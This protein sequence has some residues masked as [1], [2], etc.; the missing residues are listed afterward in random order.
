MGRRKGLQDAR[1]DGPTIIE[2][3]R[4]K[5]AER[6]DVS[7]PMRVERGRCEL[8]GPHR[9]QRRDAASRDGVSRDGPTRAIGPTP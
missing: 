9:E 4:P 6:A 8:T 5:R 2:S 1:A 7:R 3:S